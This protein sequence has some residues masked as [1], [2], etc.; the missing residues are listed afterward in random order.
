M[1]RT[2]I[3][4]I[5]LAMLLPLGARMYAQDTNAPAHPP[6]HRPGDLLLPPPIVGALEMT[7]TQQSQYETLKTA[8]QQEREAW[9]KAHKPDIDAIQAQMK[10]ARQAND[11]AT[12]GGLREQMHTALKPLYDLRKSYVEKVRDFLT[13]EQKDKLDKLFPQWK[14]G[15]G[16]P[17]P[18]G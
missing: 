5:A 10:Q 9:I 14:G 3:A 6:V 2:L 15:S 4:L 7:A 16:H 1:K 13:D 17:T 11:T 18:A 8:Y 12:M